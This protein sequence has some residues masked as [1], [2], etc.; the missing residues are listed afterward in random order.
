MSVS[1]T[2]FP[3]PYSRRVVK[4]GAAYNVHLQSVVIRFFKPR[5]RHLTFKTRFSLLPFF[6]LMIIRI[7]LR[8]QTERS[9]GSFSITES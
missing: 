2:S 6:F 5:I 3:M 9:P 8:A 1:I 7:L 4:K